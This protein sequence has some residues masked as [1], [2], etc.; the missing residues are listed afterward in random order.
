M[1]LWTGCSGTTEKV[2]AEKKN[3]STIGFGVFIEYSSEKLTL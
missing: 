2:D 3:I 1:K